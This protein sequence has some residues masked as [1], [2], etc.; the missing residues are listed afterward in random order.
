MR[1]T[2]STIAGDAKIQRRFQNT[3]EFEREKQVPASI[4]IKMSGAVLDDD[5]IPRLHESD[6]AGVMRRRQDA[7]ENVMRDR[8]RLEL[9]SYIAPQPDCFVNRR[10]LG[11]AKVFSH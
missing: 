1:P 6:G 7:Y 4:I 3:F 2:P 5:E 9:A 10:P 8:I 11:V